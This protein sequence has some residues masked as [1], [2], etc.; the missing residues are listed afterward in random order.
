M[1]RRILYGAQAREKLKAGVDGLANAV[2]AT[3]GPAGRN[4]VI[5][6]GV[7]SP[8]ITKDGVTVAREIFMQDDIENMGAQMV[9]EV[10]SKTAELAGDGTTTATVLA[11]IIVTR[12]LDAVSAGANPIDLKRGIDK[13]V[14]AVVKKLKSVSL[15]IDDDMEQL[16][17]IA[18]VSSNFDAEIGKLVTDV[19]K[20]VGRKGVVRVEDAKGSE[21]SFKIVKG[22]EVNQGWI[23]REL[24]NVPEKNEV[25]FEDPLIL[26]LNDKVSLFKDVARLMENILRDEKYRG[27]PLLIVADDI[28]GEALATLVAN[29]TQGRFPAAAIKAPDFGDTRKDGFADI[30]ALTGAK[31]IGE[32][33]GIKIGNAQLVHLGTCKKVIISRHTTT[34]IGGDETSESFQARKLALE[35]LAADTTT[36]GMEKYYNERLA[37][38]TNGVGV[39]YVGASSELESKEKKDRIDDALHATRAALE[40][41]YVPG[42]GVAYLRCLSALDDVKWENYDEETGVDIVRMAL[43]EPLSQIVGNAGKSPVEI[44]KVVMG[45]NVSVLELSWWDRLLMRLEFM[46]SQKAIERPFG[47]GYNAKTEIFENLIDAGVIDPTKVTRVA[48]EN[49]GSVAGLILTT[50]CLLTEFKEVPKEMQQYLGHG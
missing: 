45:Y 5:G 48:L 19:T 18:N 26:L 46:G 32:T 23:V 49:A 37:K 28:V 7:M 6:R 20:A 25:Y 42:G 35:T 33:Y 21:T 31:V 29:T 12:G 4:V 38:L 2:K 16:S 17:H 24:C 50:E 14:Q 40:E 10:A 41:G 27:R 15:T 44:M 3:L 39:I 1:Y 30:A 36:P 34:F 11:Q 43:R 8:H 47:F 9:K 22:L 13:G